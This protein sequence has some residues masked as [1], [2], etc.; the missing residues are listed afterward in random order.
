VAAVATV[1][2]GAGFLLGRGGWWGATRA[3]ALDEAP[4]GA[5]GRPLDVALPALP[6]APVANVILLVGDGMG[7]AQVEAARWAAF[8]TEGHF[9]FERFPVVGLT[10]TS[11]AGS[12]VTDSAAAATAIATGVATRYAAVGVGPDGR[13]LV[14]ILEAARDAGFATGLV[15]TSEIVDATP[16][17]FAAHAAQRSQRAEI[18]AQLAAS[19]VDLLIGGGRDAF[20]DAQ[21]A[22]ARARGVAVIPPAELAGAAGLPLWALAPGRLDL[23]GGS[24]PLAHWAT[25]AL[26]LLSRRSSPAGRGFFVLIEEEGIDSAAHRRDLPAMTRAL[27]R[28]DGAV[29]AAVRFAAADG[30]TLVLVV[31]DHATGGLSIDYTTTTER[32]RVAWASGKHTGEPVPLY[33]Y[34]PEEAAERFGGSYFQGEVARR[35]A[36]L[37]GLDLS[38]NWKGA[39]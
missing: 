17:G 1:A 27:L 36:P 28:F 29:A 4:I 12:P 10:S 6:A 32:L 31:G 11:A 21:L 8:G 25:R 30:R 26:E 23:P 3:I 20:E 18:A 16:A 19:R 13:R 35:L 5:L 2:F 33:A 15:T 38:A 22:A 37:L 7:A 34:G 24:P 39:P 14:S 9:V